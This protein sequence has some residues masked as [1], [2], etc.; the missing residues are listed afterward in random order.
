MSREESRG[1]ALSAEWRRLDFPI[2]T[3]KKGSCRRH[4]ADWLHRQRLANWMETGEAL[5]SG[6]EV[7]AKRGNRET[8]RYTLKGQVEHETLLSLV[9]LAI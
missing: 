1:R 2:G 9:P 5:P 4:D 7:M 3:D 6:T 8:Q